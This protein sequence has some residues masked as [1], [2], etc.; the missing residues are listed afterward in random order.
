MPSKKIVPMDDFTYKLMFDG[1]SRGNPGIAG[2]GYV[3]YENN[4]EIYSE[5]CPIGI[6][7]T[8]NEAEYLG[9]IYGLQKAV[10]LN[11]K[12]ILINGDSKLI[13]EQVTGN[14]K[15]KSKNL[16]SLCQKSQLLL[17]NFNKYGFQH[18]LR[19]YNKRADE[20][21]NIAMDNLKLNIPI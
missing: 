6:N 12:D 19:K 7:N 13:I 4:I 15:V 5:A 3:I 21:A 8:N 9:L 2:A 10:E 20:L 1:G 16:I 14:W 11:I 17:H 18:I